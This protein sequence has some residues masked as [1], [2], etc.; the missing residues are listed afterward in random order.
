MSGHMMIMAGGTGG[1]VFPALA[2]AK[3]LSAKGTQITWLGTKRGLEAS[4]IPANDIAIEWV[5][6]EGLRGKGMFSLL[7][8]PFK[9]LRAMWQSASAIHRTKPDCVLGMGGFVAGP[10]GLMA[11]MMGKPLIVHEQNAVAGL[12]NKYLAKVA[13]RVLT[14]FPKVADLP[15]SAVWLG[16]P[17]RAEIDQANRLDDSIEKP[18]SSNINVLVIGGSQGA[19]SFN[20]K[21]PSV[22]SQLASSTTEFSVWHQTGKGRNQ[23]V[24]DQYQKLELKNIKVTEFIDDMASAY[25]WADLLICRAGAMTISECC[26]AAKPALLIPFPFSAGNHQ[27]I[28]AKLMCDAGAGRMLLNEQIDSPEMLDTLQ[29]L[30][31]D[32]TQL[33]NMGELAYR[34][35][36]PNALADVTNVCQEYLNA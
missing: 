3:S 9:L 1:H 13:T 14:G 11:R 8:A 21:L 4:V 12:T 26:A 33:N 6:V 34:L 24:I 28:N 2:V 25:Q 27:I 32:K 36:K 31:S 15:K 16:N 10:G 23:A 7:L 22:F 29:K 5:S 35:H 18:I 17:V 19:H 20:T 30:L